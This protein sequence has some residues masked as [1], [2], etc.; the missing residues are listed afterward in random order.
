MDEWTIQ[1][2]AKQFEHFCQRKIEQQLLLL[3]EKAIGDIGYKGHKL[4]ESYPNLASES[5]GV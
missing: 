5:H 1:S 3:G 4:T 2:W